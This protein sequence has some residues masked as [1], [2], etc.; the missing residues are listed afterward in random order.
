MECDES[1][2][3]R[4]LFSQYQSRSDSRWIVVSATDGILPRPPQVF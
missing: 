1:Q 2:Q 4:A 3:A